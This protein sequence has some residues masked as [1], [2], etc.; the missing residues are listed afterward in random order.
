MTD[1]TTTPTPPAPAA[2]PARP[3]TPAPRT[4]RIDWS[5]VLTL[6]VLG[7][8]VLLLLAAVQPSLLVQDNTPT[9]GDMGA[10]VYAPA[11][12][13]DVLLP[14]LRLN[15]WSNDWYAGFPI[16][17]FYMVVPALLV[18][19]LDLVLPYGIAL[20]LTAVSGVLTMPIATWAFARLARLPRPAPELLVL[21]SL[22][23]LF[24]E[25]FTIYGG[26]IASTM[27][28]EIGR[29]HV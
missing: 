9:G 28:G 24:D 27:A 2:T 19:L 21:A 26:N 18:L 5:L 10:H 4:P 1:P 22:V 3:A 13:R 23:F 17:R 20:K 11:Y 16:Y 15:G 14:D 12:L 29:A 7:G 25:S 8:A 6:V